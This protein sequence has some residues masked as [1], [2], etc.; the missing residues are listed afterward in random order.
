MCYLGSHIL[1][2]AVFEPRSLDEL[3]PEWRLD[4]T[5]PIQT[6]VTKDEVRF[7][8]E[9]KSIQLPVVGA[10]RNKGKNY[11][12]SLNETCKWLASKA[13]QLGVEIYSGISGKTVISSIHIW[14]NGIDF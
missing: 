13:E 5:C 12:V 6:T 4:P 2:G 9:T 11:V 8:T 10:M 3:L 1:S 14:V 7:L